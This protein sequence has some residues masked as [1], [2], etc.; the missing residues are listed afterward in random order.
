[1]SDCVV[2]MEKKVD[3]VSWPCLHASACQSC[4]GKMD[5]RA[6]SATCPYCRAPR[7][8]D[9]LVKGMDRVQ[10]WMPSPFADLVRL[11]CAAVDDGGLALIPADAVVRVVEFLKFMHLKCLADDVDGALL[12]P[13]AHVDAIWH[14]A[15]LRPVLYATHFAT[16]DS[17]VFD[18]VVPVEKTGLPARRAATWERFAAVFG[19]PRP[20]EEHR[21]W[22]ELAPCQVQPVTHLSILSITG[23]RV[24]VPDGLLTTQSCIKDVAL[25]YLREEGVPVDQQQYCYGGESLETDC[26]LN[27]LASYGVPRHGA[28]LFIVFKLRGC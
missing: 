8:Q 12:S 25:F 24:L 11:A 22:R 2:C 28:V 27:T 4:L 6:G 7:V 20:A 1:M 9:V 13:P 3:S 14:L 23:K 15:L 26:A 19:L 10:R 21:V 17:K 16:P 5:R 18:H